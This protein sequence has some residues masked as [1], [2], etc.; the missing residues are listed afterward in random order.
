[1]D[2][3]ESSNFPST[4]S[5]PKKNMFLYTVL[6]LRSVNESPIRS[7]CL[8]SRRKKEICFIYNNNS[9]QQMATICTVS[10]ILSAKCDDSTYRRVKYG[11]CY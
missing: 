6:K 11:E 3:F 8:K 2:E 1:M 7:S 5:Y 9:R 10:E 4:P